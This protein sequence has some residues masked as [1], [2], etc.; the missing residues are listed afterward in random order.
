MKKAE[1]K[2]LGGWKNEK[3]EGG[4]VKVMGREGEGRGQ[5]PI[6]HVATPVK[7]TVTNLP[8]INAPVVKLWFHVLR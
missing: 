6:G 3:G 1:R 7:A 5:H 4:K 2:G 8:V